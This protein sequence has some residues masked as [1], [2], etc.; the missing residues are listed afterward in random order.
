MFTLVTRTTMFVAMLDYICNW[1]VWRR[2]WI[3]PNGGMWHGF[4]QG[5][6]FDWFGGRNHGIMFWWLNVGWECGLKLWN[7]YTLSFDCGLFRFYCLVSLSTP[8]WLNEWCTRLPELLFLGLR[9]CCW[10]LRVI[11]M[12]RAI[13]RCFK[14]AGSHFL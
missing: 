12:L 8:W 11:D 1:W 13:L 4:L 3:C 14:I 10:P 9:C 2:K 5:L 6:K 7:W